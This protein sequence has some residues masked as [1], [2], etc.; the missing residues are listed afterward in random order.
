MRMK[1]VK[2]YF[3]TP[4]IT[5]YLTIEFGFLIANVTKFAEGGYVTLIIAILLIS[6]NDHLVLCQE[7]QQELHPDC[8]D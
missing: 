2:L 4:L 3:M 7:N 6:I 8:Q 5:I 1:R